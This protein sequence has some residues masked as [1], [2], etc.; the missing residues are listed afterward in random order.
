MTRNRF[1]SVVFVALGPALM[2]IGCASSPKAPAETPSG[3]ASPAAATS[4][5]ADPPDHSDLVA[6]WVDFRPTPPDGQWLVDA[7]GREYFLQPV[8]KEEGFYHRVDPTHVRVRG[9][10]TLELARED[11]SFFYAKVYRKGEKDDGMGPSPR[12]AKET[13][14]LERIAKSYE[15]A[16]PVSNAMSF[17]AIGEG[18]PR[19]GQWRNGFALADVNGDAALDIVHGAR[20]RSMNGKPSIFLGDG[21]G[22]FA[23]WKEATFPAIAYDYGDAAVGDFNDDGKADLAFALH[24]RGIVAMLGDGKG[25]FTSFSEGLDISDP[26]KASWSAAPFTSRAIEA[27]DWNR[28]GR[29]DLLALSEGPARPG[30]TGASYE[31]GKRIYLAGDAG[32]S[33]G[34]APRDIDSVF[35][36]DIAIGDFNGDGRPDFATAI[37]IAGNKAVFNIADADGSWHASTLEGIRSGAFVRAV[38]TA[39]VNGDARD[40]LFISYTGTEGDVARSG[41][42]L[43]LSQPGGWRRFALWVREGRNGMTAMGAGDLDGDGKIDL[44]GFSEQGEPFVFRGS[45]NGGFT[46]ESPDGIDSASPGCRG[47]SVKLA[48]LDRDMKDE[49]V[50]GFAGER[51]AAGGSLRAWKAQPGKM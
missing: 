45:G 11:E 31:A 19:S 22:G 41:I 20:R 8:P 34:T 9:G 18:L 7:E 25:N 40:D 33:R 46:A 12:T 27:I 49:I 16:I 38:A 1:L 21:K 32:W 51:C 13:E 6:P 47:Y 29:T 48:D 42:D 28:D 50:A 4:V 15:V 23:F 2:L 39:D 44:V 43:M 36:D 30:T 26:E 5:E 10:I 37:S 17:V 3:T 24:L 14:E 35:G